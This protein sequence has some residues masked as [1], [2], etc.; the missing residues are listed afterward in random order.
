[1]LGHSQIQTFKSQGERNHKPPSNLNR[2]TK[3]GQSLQWP[4]GGGHGA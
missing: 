2:K 3:I 1:M 4:K